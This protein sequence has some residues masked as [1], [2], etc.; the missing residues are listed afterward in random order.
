MVLAIAAAVALG[1]EVQIS[2][3]PESVERDILGTVLESLGG[4]ALCERR[5]LTV[6]GTTTATDVPAALA[7]KVHGALYLL[8]ALLA[9][10][11][12]AELSGF[13]GDK[14][15]DFEFGM[16]RPLGHLLELITEFG[17][18]AS[19]ASGR[20][21]A[22]G[23]LRA[24]RVDIRRWSE[25]VER[26]VGPRVSSATKFALLLGAACNG[27]TVIDNPHDKEAAHD[28]IQLLRDLGATIEQ[29]RN[30]WLIR[31]GVKGG[32]ARVD[33]TPD[34]AEVM[35]W[36]CIAA[37]TRSSIALRVSDSAKL[38]AALRDEM[39]VV[40]R[41]AIEPEWGDSTLVFGPALASFSGTKIGAESDGISTDVLPMLAV[42]LFGAE[43]SS[44]IHD[45]VWSDRFKY[46]DALRPMGVRFSRESG[47]VRIY[48]SRLASASVPL[49]APDTRGVAVTIALAL[50][51][52]GVHQILGA[53]H[54]D[55]G[56]ENFVTRL[57][58]LGAEIE[59]RESRRAHSPL[60]ALT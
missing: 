17:A 50:S 5:S 13:G 8:P 49:V 25:S 54:L 4:E 18:S 38:G 14:L 45:D 31:G 42:Q 39:R 52:P 21:S 9:Q 15:G 60:P 37:L 48:P 43:T 3:S 51:T 16:P 23:R 40:P 36:Q 20:F 24:A 35:T 7:G 59:H 57:Q 53:T 47:G 26:T 32:S 6:R 55:R 2:N 28:L 11:G 46:L 29:R 27:T 56:Y 34:P 58:R 33:L 10:H 12:Q 30:S 19:F 22:Q 1:A 41:I 44:E